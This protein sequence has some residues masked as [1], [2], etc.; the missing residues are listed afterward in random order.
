[1]RGCPNQ[2]IGEQGAAGAGRVSSG[3]RRLPRVILVA[4]AVAM[5]SASLHTSSAREPAAR[6]QGERTGAAAG[7]TA[8]LALR[9]APSYVEP[10]IERAESLPVYV[11]P[12]G[13]SAPVQMPGVV[14]IKRTR[15]GV[16]SGRL[17]SVQLALAEPL[18]V[19]SFRAGGQAP[20]RVSLT[21][22][23]GPNGTYTPQ[24]LD[25]FSKHG[26][27][28][29]FFVLGRNAT[30][31]RQLIRRM[32]AEGHEL[33]IHTWSHPYLTRLSNE[34]IKRDLA[35]C[36]ALLGPLVDHEIRWFRPPYGDINARVRSV[37]NDAGY[38][39]AMWSVDPKD[40]QRPGSSVVAQRILNRVRDGSVV[41]LHDGGGNRAGT[42]KAMST[43]VPALVERGY[44]LVTMSELTG[45]V[46]PPLEERGMLLTIGDRQF[47]LEAGFEEVYVRVDG[48]EI[49]LPMAPAQIEGHFL[50]PARP[51]L[52]ALGAYCQWR[53]ESLALEVLALRGR[54]LV[55]LDSREM[56]ANE[57]EVFLEI[58]AVFYHGQALMPV[59][60]IA[61]ACGAQV[62]YNAAER[63][64]DFTSALARDL[65]WVPGRGF[66]LRARP[67]V[68][69]ATI[70]AW[71]LA[72]SHHQ[73]GW[74][75]RPAKAPATRRPVVVP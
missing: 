57:E 35:R 61:S 29:T 50:V 51:V 1:M 3:R 43:V 20:P 23:D 56:T 68:N 66:D 13:A 45:L 7:P 34:A 38:R 6:R 10:L 33:G 52:T 41:V 4:V 63:V 70:T 47:R 9:G 27:R 42:V 16:I 39:V 48:D 64:I 60:L 62:T 25:I 18:L 30:N 46:A 36:Q 72:L 24:L 12:P 49:E 65:G 21:F 53:P 8:T 74:E 44:E 40:W 59:R 73:S 67:R 32:S 54:F 69:G 58:P 15:A 11:Q 19:H 2:L 26:A 71:W 22:D 31:T 5:F 28:A 14:G 75:V 37:I 17:E 55:K